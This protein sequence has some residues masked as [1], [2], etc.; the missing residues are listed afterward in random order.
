MKV[1][2]QAMKRNS[3]YEYR[4]ENLLFLSLLP[5]KS[6]FVNPV[7]ICIL[8]VVDSMHVHTEFSS[9]TINLNKA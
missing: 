8:S 5:P 3:E 6:N 9:V 1:F 7:C 2:L 4:W